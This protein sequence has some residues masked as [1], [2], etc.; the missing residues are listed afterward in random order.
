MFS[1]GNAGN[2]NFA[3]SLPLYSWVVDV[4]PF[5][6]NQDL[7]NGF[8]K[9]PVKLGYADPTF[10]P[11]NPSNFQIGNTGIGILKCPEDLTALPGQGNLSYVVNMGFSRWIGTPKANSGSLYGWSPGDG[12]G[13][14]MG[15][16]TPFSDN[17]TGPG[18]GKDVAGKTGVMFLGTDTGGFGWDHKTG[19]SSIIDGSS[20]TILASENFLAGATT[21]SPYAGGVPNGQTNWACP[22]PNFIGFMA[23]DQVWTGGA[24]GLTAT[25]TDANT[26][27][28]LANFRG[29]SNPIAVAESIN[30]GLSLG[31]D[32]ACPYPNS[33]HSG[34]INVLFCDN[35]VKFVSDQ[36]DGIVWAKLITPSGSRLPALIRQLPV[37]AS[38]ID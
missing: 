7:Y 33:Y 38:T 27:W 1:P 15:V 32:G 17:M 26:N 28:K 10:T 13:G 29:A 4:L 9:R 6:D 3:M 25:G 20:T 37:D 35:S 30:Y 31:Q 21:G 24:A 23:S 8:N 19:T 34:G 22:H 11:G 18:W 5:L 12:V 2:S 16:S 14:P 36:I